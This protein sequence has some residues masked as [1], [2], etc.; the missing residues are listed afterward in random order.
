MEIFSTK[1]FILIY[2]FWGTTQTVSWKIF[3]KHVSKLIF[4]IMRNPGY[5]SD[6]FVK[7]FSTQKIWT[8]KIQLEDACTYNKTRYNIKGSLERQVE[9]YAV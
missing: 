2:A 7:I 3:P 1:L 6:G 5:D 8:K 4:K 9:S